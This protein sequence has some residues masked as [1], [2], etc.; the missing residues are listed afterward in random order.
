[1]STK[2]DGTLGI[3]STALSSIGSKPGV[4]KPSSDSSSTKVEGDTVHLTGNAMQMQDLHEAVS[5]S[6][7]FDSKRVEAL[8][9]QIAQGRYQINDHSVASKMLNFE[10][11]LAA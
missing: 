1:M 5:K 2:I 4:S 10:T 6:S 8:R 3:S 9:T 7:A 11:S